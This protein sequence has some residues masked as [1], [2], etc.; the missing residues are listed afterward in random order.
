MIFGPKADFVEFRTGRRRVAKQSDTM[1]RQALAD[2]QTCR[3][4]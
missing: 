4:P 1:A 2:F 3:R